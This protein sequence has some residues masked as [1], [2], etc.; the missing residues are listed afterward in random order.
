MCRLVLLLTCLMACIPVFL[1]GQIVNTEE[2][3]FNVEEDQK[4]VGAINLNFGLSR[5]KAGM[6]IRPGADLRMELKSGKSRWMALGG[7]NLTRFTN[8]NTPGS[9]PTNFNNRG[10]AHLRYNIEL[11]PKITMEFFSQYQFDE[12]Q[13]IDLRLLNGFGPRIQFFQTDSAYL[14]FGALYMY[15]HEKTSANPEDLVFN[16]DNRLS[17]YLSF[18]IQFNEFVNLSNVTYFQPNLSDFDDYRVTMKF[19]FSAG[20]N[21]WMAYQ[22]A[23]NLVY[24]NRPPETV[25]P[26]MFD[27]STGFSFRF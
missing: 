6:S 9:L 12:I 17:S 24:D 7:Y 27:L 15:E 25:P 1:G 26:T 19:L 20:L 22:M 16:K 13:E 2:L 8:L 5:N 23:F 11:S 14:Y 18:G 4:F 3:R 21:K 10:F